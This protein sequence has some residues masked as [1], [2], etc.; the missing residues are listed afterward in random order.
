M[1]ISFRIDSLRQHIF[2]IILVAIF[3]VL[4]VLGISGSSAGSFDK[5]VIG[6]SPGVLANQPRAIRSDE[7]LVQSQELQLQAAAGN[8]EVN[9]NVANGQ[10]MSLIT[11][12]PTKSFFAIFKPQNLFFFVLPF[13]QAFA[14]HWWFMAL[15]LCIGFYA[16]AS[17]LLPNRKLVVSL[18]SLTLLFNPFVQWWYQSI[19]LLT[20]GYALF[21]IYCFISLF[22]SNRSK[23]SLAVYTAGLA[24]FSL[25]F[26]FDLY[27]SFQI[28]IG[29]AGMAL[30]IGFLSFRYRVSRAKVSDDLSI[31]LRV[32]VGFLVVALIATVFAFSHKDVINTM[33]HTA[34]PGSRNINSGQYGGVVSAYS[35]E[36]MFSSPLLGNLQD[37]VKARHFPG[38]QSEASIFI[39]LNLI[40]TPLILFHIL[41][42]PRQTRTAPEV[43][44]LF[45]SIAVGIFAVRFF[46]PLFNLP[47]KFLLLNNVQNER[48]EIGLIV[49]CCIQLVLLGSIKLKGLTTKQA[50]AA[51]LFT[52][53]IF[54]D[55]SLRT[56]KHYPGFMSYL[57]AAILC[58]AIGLVVTMLLKK[59]FFIYGLALFLVINLANSVFVNPLYNRSQPL[60]IEQMTAAIKTYGDTRSWIGVDSGLF[61]NAPLIAGKK[62]YTG[63]QVYPQIQLWQDTLDQSHKELND[64]NRYAHVVFTNQYQVFPPDENFYTPQADVLYIKFSCDNAKKLPD[65]GYILTPDV[66]SP[67]AYPCLKLSKTVEYP[68]IN[69][70]IYS[71]NNLAKK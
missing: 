28:P 49:L 53:L 61:E 26:I 10:N 17:K 60:A 59:R 43:Y 9:H 47:Y 46:T 45:M 5:S 68:K 24:Y 20:I 23:K 6:T 35:Y 41:K 21:A 27:P 54:G 37:N 56:V 14:A 4:T 64:Y 57:S 69:Y 8:K 70:F 67:Q 63:V 48:A 58:L 52:A 1:K 15:V 31:W 55:A 30:L 29:I 16:C 51:G 19:T 39:F 25:C 3:V 12:V 62:S 33:R 65:L 34:Y 42:K 36:R 2:P 38:N 66:F 71:F 7:W 22:D 40:F 13:S 44:F 18:V 50:L 32:F 11:D